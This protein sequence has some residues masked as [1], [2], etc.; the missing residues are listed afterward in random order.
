MG[1]IGKTTLAKI[2]F[3]QIHSRFH[4]CSFIS[5]VREASK[6]SKIVQLQKQLLSE[7]LNSNPPEFYDADAGIYQLNMRFRRKKVLIV[8]DDL[9]ER[10]QLSKLAEKSDWFG[11]GSRIII[12]TRDTSFLLIEEENEENNVEMH[13]KEFQIYRMRELR[14]QHALQLFF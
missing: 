1:G 7:T 13:F 4:G 14:H 10:D 6:G 12:T 9:D 11:L 8:L 3:N 2:I 5:N